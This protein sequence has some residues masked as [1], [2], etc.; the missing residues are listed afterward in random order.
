MNPLCDQAMSAKKVRALFQE[1]DIYGI[2]QVLDEQDPYQ[3][4]HQNYF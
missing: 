2:Y 3:Q 4:V 1:G